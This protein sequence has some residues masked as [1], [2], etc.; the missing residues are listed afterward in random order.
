MNDGGT[1]SESDADELMHQQAFGNGFRV[2]REAAGLS[3]NDVV[4][5]LK[6]PVEI[7]R[8]MESSQ[9]DSL[10]APAF[11]RGYI[12]NYARFLKIPED[13]VLEMY[14]QGIPE[15]VP[16]TARSPL[17]RQIHSGE[18]KVK[19]MTYGFVFFVLIGIIMW[20][21]QS[22]SD[23]EEAEISDPVS[24]VVESKKSFHKSADIRIDEVEAQSVP[25]ME[26]NNEEAI[27]EDIKDNEILSVEDEPVNSNSLPMIEKIKPEKKSTEEVTI[28]KTG[29]DDVT[30][31]SAASGDDVLVIGTVSESWVEIGDV[32]TSRL[33]F[34]LI[35]KGGFYRV[36]GQAPFKVFL[37][38]APS[39]S[40]QLN[41]K[42]VNVLGFLRSINIA[43]V[44]IYKNGEVVAVSRKERMQNNTADE[45]SAEA[46]E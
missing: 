25:A 10:P 33:V 34:E 11:T 42:P 40:L 41:G 18:T 43:H 15:E 7:I 24:H 39:V 30:E 3:L 13:D 32:N 36:R 8:A 19:L 21:S 6:L 31:F 28:E 14:S 5:A 38:N 17:T 9:V 45:K 29:S 1:R 37:G 2:A 12:R 44:Y 23:I 20:L 46:E 16:L 27:A 35:K 4:E 22:S 26:E